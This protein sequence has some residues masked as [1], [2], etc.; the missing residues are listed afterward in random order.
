MSDHGDCPRSAALERVLPRLRN[1]RRRRNGYLASC[2][3]HDDSKPSLSIQ[4]G[5]GGKVLLHCFAGCPF[6]A[7]VAATGLE[8]S[9]LFA[10]D[11]I[12][13]CSPAAV[14]KRPAVVARARYEIRD[15]DGD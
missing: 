2:P 12:P 5:D 10:D 8:P 11:P 9:D 15:A 13:P 14:K 1:V 4:E 6:E 3:A 7:I